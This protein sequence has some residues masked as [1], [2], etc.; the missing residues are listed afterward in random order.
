M[1]YIVVGNGIG[2][3]T[4]AREL[5]KNAP[6]ESEIMVFSNEGWGYYPRPKLPYFLEDYKHTPE[7][8]IIYDKSWYKSANIELHLNEE[9]IKLNP[10]KKEIVSKQGVYRYDRLLL[11]LG[12]ESATPPIQGL[13]LKHSYTLRSLDDAIEIRNQIKSSKSVLVIGG[14]LL[15]IENACACAK[16][17]L[18]VTIIEYFPQLLPQQLDKEGSPILISLLEELGVK[19]VTNAQVEELVGENV[20]SSVQL[21]DGRT[22]PADIVMTCTG[23]I[24]RTN[25]A[26]QA[27]LNVKRG[28]IVNNFLETSDSNI[29][30]V[31]DVAEHNGRIYGIVPPT[32]EQARI[33]ALNMIN[34]RSK[35]YLGSRVSTTLKVAN[36][37]LTSI[38]YNTDLPE[39]SE[40]KYSKQDPWLYVKLFHKG[41]QLKSAII[42]GTKKGIPL[43]RKIFDQSLAENLGKLEELFPGITD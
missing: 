31:G 21:K 35:E 3:I 1:R 34:P 29:F 37:Y 30:A 13:K 25:L 18:D 8:L 16:Q 10:N 17:G 36:L 7:E 40:L 11:S 43:I 9:I 22:F 2:G 32:T 4:A 12:A 41:N 14:G 42:L 6:P 26:H 27:G 5:T 39:Y 24:P 33:A 38:G 28:I 19:T 15:G 20:V 23:I